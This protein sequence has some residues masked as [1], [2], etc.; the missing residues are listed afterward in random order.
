MRK[1]ARK[2]GFFVVGGLACEDVAHGWRRRVTIRR[3]RS[4]LSEAQTYVRYLTTKPSNV[5]LVLHRM[6][7]DNL[8]SHL[9]Q[10]M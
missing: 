9:L 2:G 4:G 10:T 1:T 3:T 6:H 5:Y 7:P 8:K